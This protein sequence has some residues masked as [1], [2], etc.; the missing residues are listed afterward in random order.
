[1]ESAHP[2]AALKSV[3]AMPNPRPE[4]RRPK[5][6][7]SPR[8][9]LIATPAEQPPIE[10]GHFRN[11]DF[12]LLSGFG[13]RSSDFR[14]A[15]HDLPSTGRILYQ[16]CR[17]GA[18][19]GAG[20]VVR[21]CGPATPEL[22]ANAMLC[23]V[24]Q[25]AYRLKRQLESQGQTFWRAGDL[26]KSCT[27]HGVR[28]EGRTGRTGLTGRTRRASQTDLPARCAAGPGSS[29]LHRK[30]QKPTNLS[31]AAPAIPIAGVRSR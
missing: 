22:A 21:V 15:E 19:A 4:D 8:S 3:R 18:V 28:G 1:M 7:R 6:T 11:S 29:A 25:A 31:G 16:P 9:E 20:R 26:R 2:R 13:L 30:G 14:A 5:E 12:G 27:E 17:R 23:A 24:N 10:S